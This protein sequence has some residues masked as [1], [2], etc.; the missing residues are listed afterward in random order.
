MRTLQ[1]LD[2]SAWGCRGHFE[3]EKLW[4]WFAVSCLGQCGHVFVPVSSWLFTSSIGWKPKPQLKQK[5]PFFWFDPPPPNVV[6]ESPK[7]WIDSPSLVLV[8]A[9]TFSFPHLARHSY[10]HSA[11][12]LNFHLFQQTNKFFAHFS[13]FFNI[14]YEHPKIWIDSPSLVLVNAVT[15]SFPRLARRSHR[16]SAGGLNFHWIDP[17]PAEWFK[18]W[19][20]SVRPKPL[21]WLRSYTDTKAWIG[22]YFRPILEP[23]TNTTF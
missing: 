10:G 5:N 21:F 20:G 9:V 6:Y 11:G 7:I 18:H 17:G 4:N 23:I 12:G 15:F 14:V 22:R 8:N 3:A 2:A 19:W 1:H 13:W 16:H